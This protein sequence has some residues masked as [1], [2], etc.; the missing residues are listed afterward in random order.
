MDEEV[1]ITYKYKMPKPKEL[2][3]S[4]RAEF[5]SAT[6]PDSWRASGPWT[7]TILGIF[8]SIGRG[9]GYVPTKEWLRLDQTWEIR[10]PD[11]SVIVLALEHENTGRVEDILDDELQKLLDV[12]ALRK[13]LVFYPIVPMI[14]EEKESTYPEIE[15]K[16]RS[17]KIK[18]PDERYIVMTIVYM[19][20][21]SIIEVCACSFDSEGKGEDLGSFQVKYTSKD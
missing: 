3:E 8:D 15:E 12:K 9:F 1:S 14:M 5:S 20:P 4:F 6:L 17:A 16:I 18:N 10:H 11:I 2:F 21:Q 19:Q 13:V 7:N